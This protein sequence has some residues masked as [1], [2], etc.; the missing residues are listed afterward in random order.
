MTSSKYANAKQ[1]RTALDARLSDLRTGASAMAK[2]QGGWIKTIRTALGMSIKDLATRMSIDSS[3]LSRLEASE[4]SARANFDSLS[5]AAEALNCEL[6]YAFVPREPLA[7][8]VA[9][10]AQ[11]SARVSLAAT[12]LTMALEAQAL[13]QTMLDNLIAQKAIELENSSTLW[14]QIA[15]E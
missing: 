4:A 9:R 6:V 10:Q 12:N 11:A 7:K 3:T 1:A 8:S 13:S 5:R 2:P 15:T 14:A